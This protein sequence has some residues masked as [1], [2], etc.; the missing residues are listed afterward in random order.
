MPD[1]YDTEYEIGQDNLRKFG[2]D[3]HNPVFWIASILILVFVIGTLLVPEAAKEAF[4]GSKGWSIDNFD[5][6]F[7]VGGNI[8][9]IFCLMLIIMPVGKVRIG[10]DDARPEFSTMSWFSMLFAAGMGIG[11]MFWSVA[12][13]VAY[14][15][16]WYGSPFNT[17]GR[18][19][20]AAA[21]AMGATM[22]HWGLHPWSIYAVVG[23]SMA[24]MTYSRGLPLTVRS[25]FY[26]LLGES[27]WGVAG[28]VI[29]TLAVLATIFGLATG[30]W[31]TAGGEWFE[32]FICN[33]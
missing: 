31:C 29:D 10:G 13:P 27:T 33:T 32:F 1:R 24:Y 20:E 2:M 23:L 28:H 6:L 8:F 22:F 9:V 11:L 21:L 4:D 14:Y 16:E 12:E 3:V 5:W 18:T 7:M 17:A 15:T 25:T 30:I 19:E 26:P